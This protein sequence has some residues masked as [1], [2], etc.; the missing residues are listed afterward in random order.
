MYTIEFQKQGLPHAHFLI[1][2]EEKYKI[3]TPKAYDQFVCVELPDPKRNPHLFELVHLHMIH[4]PCG[5]LNPTCPC[6][7]SYP[8]YRRRNTGQSIKIGSHLLDNSWVVPYNPY[9]LC[10]FNCHINVEICSDIKIVKYIYKYLCKG[11][12][13]IAFNLHTNNTNIEIDEIKEYQSA[14]WVSPPEATWRIYAFPINE[15]NPCVYHIQ[16]H[17]DG[18]QLVSFK[19]TDNIDKVI[20]NPMIKKT[21]LIEFFA[22][23]KVNKEAVTLNLL[24]REFLEFFVWSTSYRIWTHRKQRNVI[25]RIVTCHPT[26][27]ERYYLRFLLINVRA[28]KSYQDLLTFNGEYCTTFRESTEKR[29]LLLCDNNLTECMSEAS[30]YQVPSSLRHLFG[31]LLAYCNP[32]NPK[33]LWKFFENSMSEDFNKYPGLSSKEVRYKALN[34]IN[35]ILYSMGRDINEFELISKIIKVSTIAKEAKDVLSERNIIVSEKDLLLQRELNRDQQIAY[36]TILNRVF[37]NKL[38]AF[39]IDGPGGTGKTFLYRV[40]L[41]T[42]RHREFAAL[43]TASSGVAASLLLGGQTTHSRFKLTIE[44]DENFSCNISKQSSLASLIRDAKL[45]VWDESSMAKKEMI[46]ALDLLLKDLMET[47]ILFGGKVVVF[48]GDFRQTLP[49]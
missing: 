3:L 18:Q 9:L 21:M 29:G 24:Y 19:S 16:L 45:I 6:K 4:G 5:P 34:H 14:R 30:T 44:I 12:D 37:S 46:E 20:N 26:E 49:V 10:K 35:D 1:I 17:L 41:A 32:N 38:G 22:M 23:N 42:V 39:F 31:V 15:M 28:P 13:K 25:G 7:S 8:I 11:H 2:L 36:N 43:A 48:S 33:E 40:L 27:G 47:N